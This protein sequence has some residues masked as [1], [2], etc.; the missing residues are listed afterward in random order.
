MKTDVS[1]ESFASIIRVLIVGN[2]SISVILF[3]L[4]MEAIRYSC[5]SILTRATLSHTTEQNSSKFALFPPGLQE[6]L[7]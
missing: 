5:A 3:T 2:V 7:A 1:E 6:Y 4:M